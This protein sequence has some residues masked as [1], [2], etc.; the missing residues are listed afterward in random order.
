MMRLLA[1]A[2]LALAA[3]TGAAETADEPPSAASGRDI[4]GSYVVEF[5][6]EAAPVIGIE[7]SDPEIAIEAGRIH[8]Q[9]Q[10]VFEDWRY[11]R[12]GETI[13]VRPL[14]AEVEMCARGLEPGEEAIM[15]AVG[16]ADTVRHVP[17]GLWLSGAAGTVQLRFVP[18]ADDL[19]SRA[20]D[21]SGSWRVTALDGK[22]T[23]DPIDLEADWHG[24]WWEPGCAGQG[25]SYTIKGDAFDTPP[26]GNPGT[27][28]DIGFPPELEQVW[29]AMAAADTIVSTRGGEVE[30]AG[31]GRSVRLTAR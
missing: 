27:V 28:C 13:A 6:N 3:C 10:C 14:R 5:V 25:V 7:G 30:I 17:R 24:V 8:F 23:A 21:L 29:S 12:S 11:E 20:V 26:P 16:A 19:A 31:D 15:A 4:T 9:S 1:F 18:S 2:A 22:P